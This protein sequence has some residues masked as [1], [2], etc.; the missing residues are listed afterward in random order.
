MASNKLLGENVLG[1]EDAFNLVRDCS[2]RTSDK[3][4]GRPKYLLIPRTARYM[5]TMLLHNGLIRV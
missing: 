5:N 4:I 2:S 1:A 3:V